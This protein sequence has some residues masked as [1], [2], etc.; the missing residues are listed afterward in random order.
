MLTRSAGKI[1]SLE[2]DV[3]RGLGAIRP[4]DR[5]AVDGEDLGGAARPLSQQRALFRFPEDQ[6]SPR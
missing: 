6:D 3:N 4:R 2:R 5:K 1:P